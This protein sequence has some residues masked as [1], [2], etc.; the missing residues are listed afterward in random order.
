MRAGLCTCAGSVFSIVPVCR[1]IAML[2]DVA[3][4]ECRDGRPQRVIRR[5]HPVILVPV[6]ARL[7]E[8]A[9]HTAADLFGEHGEVCGGE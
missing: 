4:R 5:K 8:P 1:G 2:A 9:D 6:F 3:D 7:R